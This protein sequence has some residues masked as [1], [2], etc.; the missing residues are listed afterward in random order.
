[1]LRK[2]QKSDTFR[3]GHR[4]VKNFVW[5]GNK[6]HTLLWA[7][8][9]WNQTLSIADPSDVPALFPAPSKFSLLVLFCNRGI[10]HVE[11]RKLFALHLFQAFYHASH[12]NFYSNLGTPMQSLIGWRQAPPPLIL[13]DWFVTNIAP[14]YQQTSAS[15]SQTKKKWNPYFYDFIYLQLLNTAPV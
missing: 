3:V 7:C 6:Q 10:D 13:F 2:K 8:Y 12:P 14:P 9:N 11:W 5:R 15:T 4:S 1:M